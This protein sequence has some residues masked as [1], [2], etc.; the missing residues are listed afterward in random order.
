[1]HQGLMLPNLLRNRINY[2]QNK[3]YDTGL[4]KQRKNNFI[5]YLFKNIKK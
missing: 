4:G 3:F 5:F 2:D 1:M